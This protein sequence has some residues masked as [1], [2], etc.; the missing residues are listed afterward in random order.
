MLS[1]LES[2]VKSLSRFTADASHEIR[3]PLSIIR[4]TAEIAARK[5]RTAESYRDA[6]EQIVKES[7]RMTQLVDDLLFLAR[8]DA[9]SVEMPIHALDLGA[10]VETSARSCTRLPRRNRSG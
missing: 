10:L 5:S 4:A 3:T 7:E 1:R 2:A 8:C 9:E 6:L